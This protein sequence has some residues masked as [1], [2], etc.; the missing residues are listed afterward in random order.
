MLKKLILSVLFIA[1]VVAGFAISNS[2]N[3]AF[4]LSGGWACKWENSGKVHCVLDTKTSSTINQLAGLLDSLK[5]SPSEIPVVGGLVPDGADITKWD[6]Q[7]LGA[8]GSSCPPAECRDFFFDPA[9]SAAGGYPVFY[10]K[11]HD[12]S[13]HFATNNPLFA[14]IRQGQGTITAADMADENQTA[15]VGGLSDVLKDPDG[16]G[17]GVTR[18]GNCDRQDFGP[19][20]GPEY[21]ADQF[22][23]IVESYQSAQALKDAC[24]NEAPLSFITCPIFN[25]V[26][27]GISQLIGGQ[28]TSGARDGLLID[29]LTITP[30]TST[31]G[32]NVMQAFVQQ[33]VNLANLIYVVVFLLLIFSSSLPLGLDNYTIKKM[34]PK[35]IAAVI[36]TQFSFVISQLVIDFFNLLGTLVPN[37]IFA[38]SLNTVSPSATTSG[39]SIISTGLQ[40]A[41][42]GG[43][44]SGALGFIAAGG[45]ILIIIL[46]FIAI[47]AVLVGFVYMVLRY[48]V[49]YILVIISPLAFVAWVL[50]GTEKFFSSWW[51][52]FIRVNAVFPMITGMLA[53]AIVLSQVLIASNTNGATKLIAMLIPIVALFLIP[54][55]LK[56]TTQGMNALA[57]GVLGATAGKLGAGAKG[58]QK[59]GSAAVNKGKA[60]GKEA[61]NDYRTKKAGEAF[62]RGNKRGGAL[63]MGK[64]PTAKGTHQAREAAV[65]AE[66]EVAERNQASLSA[67]GNNLQG[68]AGVDLSN[69]NAIQQR[70][71][72]RGMNSTRAAQ[73]AQIIHSRAAAHGADNPSDLYNAELKQV[74][75]GQGSQ[76]LG[77]SPG[78][79]AMQVASVTE[80]AKLGDFQSIYEAQQ[81][82]DP[83]TGAAKPY[84]SQDLVMKGIDPHIGDV[85]TK[86]PDIVKG[87]GPAFDAI[88]ADKFVQMDKK[89]A[90]RYVQYVKTTPAGSA[91]RQNLHNIQTEFSKPGSDLSS[92]LDPTA[93]ATIN[94]PAHGLGVTL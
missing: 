17:C 39:G 88:G 28:Q 87:S 20:S 8:A 43:L 64:L 94:D 80:L 24:E 83:V 54:K 37:I 16:S 63:L 46:A 60:A 93:R 79:S 6:E 18:T 70:L 7:L 82:I 75:M 47:I 73:Q 86:A 71:V 41:I 91:A 4:A 1:I 72:D 5:L 45:W 51:K 74:A 66:R 15:P 58:V 33:V 32:T 67:T 34:L 11:D 77:V 76:L 36:L 22:K 84:I 44:A 53:V 56:W 90:A 48:L 10:N 12:Q 49:I 92:R 40:G 50:P 23:K 89:T 13:L 42:I 38:L 59:A 65:K 14:G 30:L 19:Y 55:T 62:G 35:F 81:P 27:D 69:V 68:L 21:N 9:S 57:A 2:P 78:D 61:A 85:M 31:S 29:F 25:G 3:K 26:V 52:N